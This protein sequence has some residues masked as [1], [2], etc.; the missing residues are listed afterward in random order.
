MHLLFD[1]DGTLCDS[2]PL[3][4]TIGAELL[5]KHKIEGVTDFEAGA[6][7]RLSYWTKAKLL[8]FMLRHKEELTKEYH[9]HIQD[10]LPIPGMPELLRQL[11]AQGHKLS[12]LS[13]NDPANL[14]PFFQTHLPDLID[15]LHC[16]PG[17]GKKTPLMLQYLKF[18]GI[19]PKETVYIGDDLRDIRSCNQIGIPMLAV[20][21][22]LNRPSTLI[23]AEPAYIVHSVQELQ[24][25][26]HRKFLSQNEKARP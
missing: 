25:M 10:L 17:I 24:S 4:R 5:A 7:E 12:I 20:S 2:A 18:H 19:K 6:L 14:R 26:L 21:W 15:E 23:S 9:K 1:F 8:W 22:G 13:S 11:K 16:V 3:L